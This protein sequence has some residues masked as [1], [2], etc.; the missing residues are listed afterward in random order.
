[1]LRSLSP[2][3]CVNT[4][5]SFRRRALRGP[6]KPKHRTHAGDLL[7]P[8]E[9]G[10]QGRQ[11]EGCPL[12]TAHSGVV[13]RGP[14]PG[15]SG[16][17][18]RHAHSRK[19]T[20]AKA[21]CAPSGHDG[22]G[23]PGPRLGPRSPASL[24]RSPPLGAARSSS[25][26]PGWGRPRAG[27]VR[28]VL[29]PQS[30]GPRRGRGV[31]AHGP[32]AHAEPAARFAYLSRP[33]GRATSR[34]GHR[35]V[36]C[37]LCKPTPHAARGRSPAGEAAWGPRAGPGRSGATRPR[38]GGLRVVQS[39]RLPG[40]RAGA[41]RAVT[42]E[43][44]SACDL[45]TPVEHPNA[46]VSSK[47]RRR[48]RSINRGRRGPGGARPRRGTRSGASCFP[49]APPAPAARARKRPSWLRDPRPSTHSPALCH[50]LLSLVFPAPTTQPAINPSHL[51]RGLLGLFSPSN[52]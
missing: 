48:A 28:D 38:P 30:P 7:Q 40:L 1:M 49:E 46:R 3:K 52:N 18:P 23:S 10:P 16:F 37:G 6:Q 12:P 15:A 26:E 42:R 50:F 43:H 29:R 21:A 34:V 22:R 41:G 47:Q 20:P 36:I 33:L 8:R 19:P 11:S 13:G 27:R 51:T 39:V 17:F 35:Q 4:P 45:S 24:S 5:K 2:G 32:P 31:R 14:Q 9:L 44:W 25:P